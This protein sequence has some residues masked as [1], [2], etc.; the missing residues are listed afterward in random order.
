MSDWR[1]FFYFSKGERR[2]LI[3]LLCFIA[4]AVAILFLTRETETPSAQNKA[5]H[6]DSIAPSSSSSETKTHST[7]DKTPDHR[8]NRQQTSTANKPTPETM[9]ERIKRL[10]SSHPRYSKTEKLP[11]GSTIELNV[12]DTAMLKKIPGIG[13][14]FARRIVKYRNLLGGYA[15]VTQ[16]AEVYGID[17]EKYHALSPWF[18]VD[19]NTIRKLYVNRLPEDS[20]RRHPYI[21]YRQ[22][23]A[24]ARLRRLHD[25]LT[26]WEN[27]RLLDEFTDADIQRLSPYLSFE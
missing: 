20:L 14:V 25:K 3:V 4:A 21:N 1:N 10:T 12:A 9:K 7:Y 22:A 27:L 23:R 5:L 17:E 16:L 11:A 8:K 13:S 19:K 6:T 15:D 18:T 2:A 26:G 24:I